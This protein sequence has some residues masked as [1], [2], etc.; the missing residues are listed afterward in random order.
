MISVG[1]THASS[2]IPL[3]RSSELES[4]TL[5][6]AF[7][8][9]KKSALPNF[10]AVDQV[11]FD[12]RA[13]V[14]VAGAVGGRRAAA[15][16]EAVGGDE[17]ARH[18]GGHG[19]ASLVA[20]GAD[21][22]GGVLGGHLVEVGA[23]SE[24]GVGVARAARLRDPVGSARREA[25]GRRAVDV[26]AENADVVGGCSP[27]ERRL[28]G[29]ARCR[30]A[31]RSRWRGGVRDR[32]RGLVG[33]RADVAGSVL[34]GDLVVV[35]P[36]AETAVGVARAGGLGDAVRRA[37]GE[38]GG[39]RA[40][41]VVA[42]RRRRCRWPRPGERCGRAGDARCEPAGSA[43]RGRVGDRGRDLVGEPR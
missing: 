43:R 2:V 4:L 22:A 28:T 25:R 41:E 27:R 10:P 11:V 23:R 21:V 40:V 7:V 36:G 18:G 37:G 42:A 39:G 9:L 31:G 38:A 24:A 12:D 16:V 30:Q 6:R 15:L 33:S 35:G 19:C 34:G 3:V 1:F 32:R 20:R 29:R 14:A 26:V 17:A 8:P 13:G 5:T